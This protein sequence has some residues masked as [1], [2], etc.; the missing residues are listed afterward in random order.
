MSN[1]LVLVETLPAPFADVW[2]VY[3]FWAH[4]SIEAVEVKFERVLYFGLYRPTDCEDK[5]DADRPPE[6]VPFLPS[7]IDAGSY[8]P[9]FSKH[10]VVADNYLFIGIA[11][12][13][14]KDKTQWQERAE[15]A[16][17]EQASKNQATQPKA[18]IQGETL[19]P[20]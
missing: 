8:A 9:A 7:L 2:G 14:N 6:I 3:S 12:G 16:F 11:D 17:R 19:L 10:L 4:D 1:D 15:Q 5:C 13:F 20:H 18:K